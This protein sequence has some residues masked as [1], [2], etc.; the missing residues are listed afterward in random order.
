MSATDTD[1][2]PGPAP[3]PT[4][5]RDPLLRL[6][7]FAVGAMLV[8][9]GM[10]MLAPASAAAVSGDPRWAGHVMAACCTL[11]AGGVLF[12][13]LRREGD[14]PAITRRGAFLLT[15]LS[16]I[17][18]PAFASLPF[19]FE[20]EPMTVVDAVFEA[21]S[22]ITTT[23]STV[24]SG[25]DARDAGFLLWRS[26]LQWVGGVGIILTAIV[27]LPFLR[28]GGMQLFKTESSDPNTDQ[29]IAGPFALAGAIAAL[30]TGLTL[31]CAFSY[32]AFGMDAFDAINHAMT[33]LSTGG[34]STHDNSLAYFSRPGV[35]WTACVFMLAGA[36]PFMT[37][38]RAIRGRPGAL[39]ADPQAPWFLG[40][41]ALV[42]LSAG[43]LLARTSDMGLEP[44]LRH[45]ATNIISVWT[46]TGYASSD[47]TL[48]GPAFVGLFFA[49]TFLGA[50]AGSTTGGVK[51]YRLQLLFLLARD[52]L[53]RLYDP[54]AVRSRLYGGRRVSDEVA[55]S[56]LAFLALFVGALSLGAFALALTGLDTTTAVTGA[57]TALCNVGPGLGPII[58]PVGNFATLPDAA[59]WVLI[60][61][62]LLGRLELFAL[63]VVFDPRFWRI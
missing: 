32:A 23:G 26:I 30:Y 54:R 56:V 28:I 44:A 8:G 19:L 15:A 9:L 3:G 16:W 55:L 47:Y 57:A 25:L 49:V 12:T 53:G 10:L 50:C 41:V 52:H 42:C 33:T 34:Y 46:T 22:G 37:Y 11:F 29:I 14:Q 27:M 63:I 45:A 17:L 35:H 2:V 18:L 51:I 24:V 4:I 43:F 61:L 39:L 60:A 40:G 38:L 48:W 31:L 58:G 20:P 6:P 13:A 1:I 5:P 7:L 21:V 62:M 36:L 59:K